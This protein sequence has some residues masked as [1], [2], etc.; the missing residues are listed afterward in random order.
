MHDELPVLSFKPKY[1][2][3]LRSG[4]K[5]QTLRAVTPS[6]AAPGAMFVAYCR[7]GPQHVALIRRVLA[8]DIVAFDDLT[9]DD[10]LAC[11]HPNVNEL[12][13]ALR[14][15]YPFAST[16]TRIRFGV[17]PKRALPA[18]PAASEVDA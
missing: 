16:L 8:T 18:K 11:G 4:E 14:V 9:D 6:W 5:V 15:L 2:A 1:A 3:I 13:R 12:K 17:V 10:A 7:S